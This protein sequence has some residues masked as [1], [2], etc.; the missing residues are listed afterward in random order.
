MKTLGSFFLA[1]INISLLPE[2]RAWFGMNDLFK[3]SGG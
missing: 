3:A 2:G 1:V